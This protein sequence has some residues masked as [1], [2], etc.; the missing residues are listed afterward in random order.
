M[1]PI[2]ATVHRT[3]YTNR[4][5]TAVDLCAYL[6]NDV[7][8]WHPR[9]LKNGLQAST[10]VIRALVPSTQLE[11]TYYTEQCREVKFA[12][13]ATDLTREIS[14]TSSEPLSLSFYVDRSPVPD[15]SMYYQKLGH[16][17]RLTLRVKLD[18]SESW[19][20]EWEKKEWERQIGQWKKQTA[21]MT[22][23]DFDWVPWSQPLSPS[24]FIQDHPRYLTGQVGIF[25]TPV[26]KQGSVR[27]TPVHYLS[28]EARQ[29]LFIDVSDIND[30]RLMSPEERD[31]IAPLAQPSVKVFAEGEEVSDRYFTVLDKHKPIY[32][33]ETWAKKVLPVI[34]EW[35]GKDTVDHLLVVQ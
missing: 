20:N 21:E 25:V 24:S 28:D 7:I 5:D 33:G 31:H 11:D 16:H 34:A 8:E 15:F 12:A 14:S 22:E 10:H 35:H 26:Q 17:L 3:G 4:T 18:P 6:Q 2:I 1:H 13:T 23:A 9:E 29:P 32:V 30:L 27:S 19:E